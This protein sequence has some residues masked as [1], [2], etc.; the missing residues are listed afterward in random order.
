MKAASHFTVRL[1]PLVTWLVMVELRFISSLLPST[2]PPCGRGGFTDT[3]VTGSHVPLEA[4]CPHLQNK[5]RAECVRGSFL[6]NEGRTDV[7]SNVDCE[8]TIKN[9]SDF[10]YASDP[11]LRTLKALSR[12]LPAPSF[13]LSFPS[14]V[15][16]FLSF[17]LS[18]FFLKCWLVLKAFLSA[19][20]EQKPSLLK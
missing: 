7:H 10:S 15:F 3:K 18:F 1:A 4:P 19:S 9:T 5:Q 16:T 17:S 11:W 20:P 14:F 12:F 2:P 6:Q 13:F 8:G